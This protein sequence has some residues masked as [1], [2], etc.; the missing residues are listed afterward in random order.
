MEKNKKIELTP[1]LFTEI[2]S[3]S[4]SRMVNLKGR[5]EELISIIEEE[6]EVYNELL[7][8]RCKIDKLI[9]ETRD[10]LHQGRI[11]KYK[12]SKELNKEKRKAK[13]LNRIF[14]KGLYINIAKFRVE[15]TT[16]KKRK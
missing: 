10:N 9:V 8:E 16:S 7:E 4:A 13:Q 3:E 15:E 6:L 1:E 12:V 2:S 5:K 14:T 11:N